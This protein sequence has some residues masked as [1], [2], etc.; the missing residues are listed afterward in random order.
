MTVI[1]KAP[2]RESV[3][4]YE[5]FGRIK[6][7][8]SLSHLGCIYAANADVAVAQA[9]MMY[10]EKPYVELCLTPSDAIAVVIGNREVGKI[11]FA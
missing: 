8:A 4:A 7:D 11:G 10:S 9:R 2:V 5:V 3:N 1:K 6:A